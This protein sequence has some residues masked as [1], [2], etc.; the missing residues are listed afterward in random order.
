MA[1]VLRAGTLQY[2]VAEILIGITLK[3]LNS[4]SVN[5]AYSM[6]RISMNSFSCLWK[7]KRFRT[8]LDFSSIRCFVD[9][10][11]IPFP[12]G[13][14]TKTR[15]SVVIPCHPK[16]S[17]LI[18]IVLAGLEENCLNPISEVLIISPERL[19]STIETNLNL[20]FLSDDL[21][22][23]D[24]LISFV[25]MK[26]P[27]SQF[28]WIIQQVLK[29]QTSLNFT[30][31]DNILVMDSDTVLTKPTLFVNEDH[32]ILSITREYHRQYISQYQNFSQTHFDT[33]FSY[34]T[35]FQLW[36]RDLITALWEGEKISRWLDCADLSSSSS[37]SEFHTYGSFLVE[38]FPQR[39]AY[40]NWGNIETS[41][42]ALSA[43]SYEE[44][45]S[46]LPLARSVS[47]HSYS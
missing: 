36:Q 39:F 29:I 23:G 25:K 42:L 1:S 44:I 37:I 15:I 34:V 21:I 33:G 22:L 12:L 28:G 31:E 13:R 40:A 18:P 2:R 8:L 6:N 7:I 17:A 3:L 38:K 4:L 10:C 16:D 30:A 26:F 43:N 45:K 41:R 20:R 46:L 32:Q 19:S 14:S 35:H 27:D 5:K 9:S 24:S 47:I 11:Q